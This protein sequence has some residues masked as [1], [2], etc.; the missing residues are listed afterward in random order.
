MKRFK[1]LAISI[2]ASLALTSCST[3]Q[4]YAKDKKDGVYFTV[5]NGWHVISQ[6]ALNSREAMSTAT[7]AAARLAQ[8]TWQEAYSKDGEAKAADVFS[9]SAPKSP[10][11]YVRVRD[12]SVD[13]MQSV[14]YNSLRD[15]IVPLTSWINKGS[16][17]NNFT[18]TDDFEA[19][20]KIAR[21]VHTIYAFSGSDGVNQ[22]INQT[23]LVSNDRTKLYVLLVRAK[24]SDFSKDEKELTKIADSFTVLGAK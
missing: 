18:L 17:G 16:V 12:L 24:T 1:V 19:V 14:S 23:A 20:Q 22:T 5:P 21:G 10:L 9:L 4:M 11:V 13:E 6:S 8:V 3:S 15:I 2:M 7:G